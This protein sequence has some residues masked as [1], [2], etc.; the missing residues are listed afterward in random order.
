MHINL[1]NVGNKPAIINAGDKIVQMIALYQPVMKE[2]VEFE[3]LEKLYENTTSE[4]GADGF[5]STDN[6]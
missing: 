3:S 2:A 6:K 1:I 4:R 5:G